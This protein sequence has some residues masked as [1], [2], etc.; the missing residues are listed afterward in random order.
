MRRLAKRE[1]WA[2][3][4][5][6]VVRDTDAVGTPESYA[7]VLLDVGMRADV[8]ETTY[9]H[10]LSGQDPVLEWVRGT[11]LRPIMAALSASDADEFAAQLKAELRDAY[12]P[13][14]HGTVFPFRRVFAVGQKT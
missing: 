7:S 12:P 2:A 9:L 3:T 6:D 8:W 1:Q 13:G 11:G 14:P 5:R 10:V 4:L